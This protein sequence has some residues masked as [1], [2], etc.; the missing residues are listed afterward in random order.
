MDSSNDTE[1]AASEQSLSGI[2]RRPGSLSSGAGQAT[3]E[4]LM[5]EAD[6][7]E[8]NGPELKSKEGAPGEGGKKGDASEALPSSED[9]S[10]REKEKTAEESSADASSD[11]EEGDSDAED[12]AA[13]DSTS[14][15]AASGK[16]PLGLSAGDEPDSEGASQK[17]ISFDLA[18]ELHR[19]LRRRLL[20]ERLTLRRAL[21]TVIRWWTQNPGEATP[22]ISPLIQQVKS[23]KAEASSSGG[24]DAS[25]AKQSGSSFRVSEELH[26]SFRLQLVDEDAFVKEGTEGMIRWFVSCKPERLRNLLRPHLPASD[27]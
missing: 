4:E 13:E 9:N 26:T 19:D 1:S 10:A 7:E 21:T 8:E 14:E 12:S 24:E 18:L 3:L 6:Q 5:A 22:E 2:Q 15:N 16:I 25:E 27:G 11:S 20:E 17:N 23:E